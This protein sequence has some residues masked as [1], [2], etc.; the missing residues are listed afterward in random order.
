M[1]ERT[2]FL[3]FGV[4]GEPRGFFPYYVGARRLVFVKLYEP[5]KP[6]R[7]FRLT[8]V[9]KAAPW[10]IEEPKKGESKAM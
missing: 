7:T 8:I 3:S 4:R 9:L 2:E 5:I 6:G 1:P 10:M